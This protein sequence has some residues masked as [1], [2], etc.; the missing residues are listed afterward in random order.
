MLQVNVFWKIRQRQRIRPKPICH[1]LTSVANRYCCLGGPF[2][3]LLPGRLRVLSGCLPV[4]IRDL[5]VLILRFGVLGRRADETGPDR[6]RSEPS[7]AGAAP[8]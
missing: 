5:S 2:A 4:L 7:A 8:A 6:R 1:R 3:C